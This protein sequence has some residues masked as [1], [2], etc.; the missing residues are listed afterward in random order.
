LLLAT[1]LECGAPFLRPLHKSTRSLRASLER[2]ADEE[3]VGA[4]ADARQVL[5][6]ALLG[7]TAATLHPTLA[8]F[9]A[10][11]TILERVRA[12]EVPPV[13]RASLPQ[14]VFSA[15]GA[16]LCL[17]GFTALG[18]WMGDAHF[19]IAMAGRCPI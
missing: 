13:Q 4:D 18:A 16:A 19:V 11:D 3:A 6:S 15:Q 14:A 10:G 17:A 5:R 8:A 1:V 2:W 12:L 9:S 7:V